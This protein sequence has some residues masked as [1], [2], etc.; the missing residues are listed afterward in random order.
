MTNTFFTSD[1]HIGHK[2]VAGIRG[3]WDE[4]VVLD[5]M[6]GGILVPEAQPD[7]GEHARELARNWDAV[8]RP[9]DTVWVLGDISINGGQHALDW[10]EA[11]P[12]IK[13]LIA[14]NHDPVHE[15]FRTAPKLLRHWM[16]YF[17]SVQS[18]ARLRFGDQSYLL[19]HFPYLSWGEGPERGGMEAA[20]DVQWRLPDL[21]M[22]LLHGHTHG[23]E[24]AHGHSYHV[25][26]DAHDLQLVP[27]STIFDWLTSL[28]AEAA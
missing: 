2:K 11:R 1:L 5:V 26:V 24:R 19:S 7:A 4:D 16:N 21:G 25:G 22:P 28:K 27:Q 6:H 9:G 15:Q 17:E 10:I 3:F 8:V 12:G 14:G 13:R 20:R 18:S 23:K